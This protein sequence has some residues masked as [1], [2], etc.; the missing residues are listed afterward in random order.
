VIDVED[1][2]NT[3]GTAILA[4]GV[5]LGKTRTTAGIIRLAIDKKRII[6]L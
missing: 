2:L 4:D 6:V 3:F 5:G 1:K